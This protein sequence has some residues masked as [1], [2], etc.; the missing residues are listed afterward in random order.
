M[1]CATFWAG[2]AS[3]EAVTLYGPASGLVL[4]VPTSCYLE[5]QVSGA[6]GKGRARRVWFLFSTCA[7]RV[8]CRLLEDLL[9]SGV[10]VV[11]EKY[12]AFFDKEMYCPFRIPLYRSTSH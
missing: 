1:R 11:S 9:A 6:S 7:V 2:A 10:C 8:R 5:P 4:P 12:N 3:V